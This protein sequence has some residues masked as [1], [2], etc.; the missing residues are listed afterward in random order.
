MM[1]FQNL[2][3]SSHVEETP[4]S[5]TPTPS[6]L[7]SGIVPNDHLGSEQNS[8]LTKNQR[9]IEPLVDPEST[10]IL[11][12]GSDPSGF[13][14][15]T[16]MVMSIDKKSKSVKLI[17]FPR[18]IYIDYSP[19][20]ISA[21]KKTKPAYLKEK[22][23][24]RINA[25]A[26]IGNAIK[27]KKDIGRFNKPYIDFIADLIQ[28]V[29]AIRAS[30]YAYVKVGGFRKIVDSFG[31][32]DVYVPVL[33]NYKD[34]AQDFSV[35]IEPGNQHL[36]GRE[37]EGYVR[38]RQGYDENGVFHNYGDLFR[39]ENQNRF[40]Q[41][42]ITQH[43]TLNNLGKL[44]TVADIINNN[45]VT[46]VKGWDRIVDYGALAEEALNNDYAISDVQLQATEKT[47]KGSSYVMIKTKK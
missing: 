6:Q 40:M 38:F 20:V 28:E 8:L 47:I 11:I 36:N 27:Y 34:P 5:I 12:L 35:Y 23:I 42:F 43:V 7:E 21:L 46:S 4:L 19:E 26:T 25:A 10:N 3:A 14:F 45:V 32:V 16:L 13:N 24:Y 15:D 9:Y 33:M 17:S 29:F 1:I 31:G 37:A 44:S 41:A 22:G 18:D 2:S 39:K 30:D